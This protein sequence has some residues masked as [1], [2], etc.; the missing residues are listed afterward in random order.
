[1]VNTGS[2]T[3]APGAPHLTTLGTIYSILEEILAEYQVRA[4][5]LPEKPRQQLLRKIALAFFREFGD[6]V[7]VIKKA[8]G[9]TGS[10]GDAGRVKLREKELL[11][12]PFVQ[13]AA[14]VGAHILHQRGDKNGPVKV[15]DAL[16]R[17]N[18]LDWSRSNPEWQ[19]VLLS[20][21]KVLSGTTARRFA[22]RLIAYRIGAAF[23]EAELKELESDFGSCVPRGASKSLPKQVRM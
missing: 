3:V 22:S 18:K 14:A 17:L 8:L 23:Q 13:L 15:A 10:G 16:A 2:N 19:G 5:Q 1:L 11:M 7:S 12:K 9:D 20:G 6:R 21:E 4:D